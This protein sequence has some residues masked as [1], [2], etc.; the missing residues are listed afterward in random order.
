MLDSYRTGRSIVVERPVTIPR[1]EAVSTLG[2][3]LVRARALTDRQREALDAIRTSLRERGVA[4]SRVELATAMGLQNPSG[5]D[6]HLSALAKKGWIELLPSVDRGIRLLREGLPIVDADHLPSVAA[7]TPHVIEE[8]QNLP[9][10]SDLESIIGQ[11]ESRPDFCVRVEGD[12]L[13][14]VGLASGDIVAIRR[15]PEARNGDIV[16]ARIGEEVTLKRYERTGPD[17]VEFQP[18]STNAE[19]KPIRVDANT[20]DV[21]IVGIVVGAIIGTRRGAE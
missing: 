21:A 12:S 16:L 5:V 15:Q 1:Q 14:K 7:G 3:D 11:F 18:A 13:D 8:C 9:R 17:T 4:P 20:E 2:G 6:G 19:H 10:I